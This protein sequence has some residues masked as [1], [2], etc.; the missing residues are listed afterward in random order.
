[1]TLPGRYQHKMSE[2][3]PSGMPSSD[4]GM[5]AVYEDSRN[6]A[7]SLKRSEEEKRDKI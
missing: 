6:L 2:K 1:M 7:L 3:H 4:G 5:T